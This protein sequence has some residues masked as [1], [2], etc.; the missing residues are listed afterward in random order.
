ML[1]KA[2]SGNDFLAIDFR[3]SQQI[4]GEWHFWFGVGARISYFSCNAPAAFEAEYYPYPWMGYDSFSITVLDEELAR[5]LV[6]LHTLVTTLEG[7]PTLTSKDENFR[8]T[9]RRH[10][11][12]GYVLVKMLIRWQTWPQEMNDADPGA[13]IQHSFEGAFVAEPARLPEWMKELGEAHDT[14]FDPTRLDVE[15]T[16]AA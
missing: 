15:S 3:R 14:R 8:L 5:F 11:I 16:G 10:N 12:Y 7:E 4:E 1:I 2:S 13:R 6:D 9:M